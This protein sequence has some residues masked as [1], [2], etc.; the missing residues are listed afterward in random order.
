MV[1]NIALAAL[2]VYLWWG[3]WGVKR[4]DRERRE[5]ARSTRKGTAIKARLVSVDYKRLPLTA[6]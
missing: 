2:A 1:G 3:I 5:R 6:P 4:L